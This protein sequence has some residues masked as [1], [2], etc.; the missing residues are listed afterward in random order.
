LEIK[1]KNKPNNKK[2]EK[3]K[4]MFYFF[5]IAISILINQEAKNLAQESI[6]EKLKPEEIFETLC[7]SCH[8]KDG[9]G[10]PNWKEMGLDT[11]PANFRDRKFNSREPLSD[12]IRV[13]RDG[14]ADH[15]LSKYMPAFGNILSER[16]IKELALYLKSL[17][18]D[19]RYPQGE[20]NFLRTHYTT[21]A[22]PEDE[23]I[24]ITQISK[25]YF[26]HTLYFAQRI[27]PI[28]QYEI[29]GKQ[30]FENSKVSWEIE[31]GLKSTIFHNKENLTILSGGVET[32]VPIKSEE[33]FSLI[34]YIAF[35]KGIQD[36]L[37]FQ[38]SLKIQF[39][40]GEKTVG[41]L[42]S[43]ALNFITTQKTKRGIF[44]AIESAYEWGK[45][46]YIH[47]IPQ[48]YFALSKRGHIAINLGYDIYSELKNI[49]PK[50][51]IRG[52]LLWEFSEGMP[53]EGW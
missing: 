12:W 7:S 4:S 51:F 46:N 24:Y 15:G 42:L 30:I 33:E 14:G 5:L 13:I 32:A 2:E 34:P 16:K 29:K 37:S 18:Y 53:Y 1:I 19:K 43:G 35:G 36:T 27:G 11:P 48:L 40:P 8:G 38:S 45:D 28:Y 20:L 9:S 49:T 26:S 10:N 41:G 50:Y 31:L 25:N 52:F 21:K 23:F 47:L 3:E 44:P 17:G 22:F 6:Y 39:S